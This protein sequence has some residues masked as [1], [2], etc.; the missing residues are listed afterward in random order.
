MRTERW[1]AFGRNC[2]GELHLYDPRRDRRET[3]DLAGANAGK[4]RELFGVVRGRAGGRCRTTR[5]DLS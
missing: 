4:A 5:D 2:G 3:R 1:K